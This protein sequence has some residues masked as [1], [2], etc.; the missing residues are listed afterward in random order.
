M[1]IQIHYKFH[2]ILPI[3][4]LVMAQFVDFK[5][6]AITQALLMLF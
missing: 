3:G 5:S 4:P 1:I 2:K 6:R